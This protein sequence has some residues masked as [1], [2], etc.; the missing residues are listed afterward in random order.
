VLKNLHNHFPEAK[1]DFLAVPSSRGIL[2]GNPIVNNSLFFDRR[3]DSSA[4]FLWTLRRSQYDLVIDLYGNPRTAL[5]TYFSAAKYRVGFAFRGRRY[6]YNIHVPSRGGE[7]HNLEFNLDVLRPLGI[8][9]IDR[10]IPFYIAREDEEYVEEFLF[11]NRLEHETIVA[12]NPG[13]TWYTKQW[14]LRKFAELG[15][16]L[17]EAYR[18]KIVLVWGPGEIEKAQRIQNLMRQPSFIP[19]PTTL[20][21]LAALFKKCAFVV[22]NDAGPMHLAAVLGIPTLGIYGPTNPDYQGPIGEKNSWVRLNGLDC[23]G[24]NLTS[25]PIGHLCMERL[26][27]D[28]VMR[29]VQN[30]VEQNQ[31]F[32]LA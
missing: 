24:C 7:V 2:E 29:A 5:M 11:Q 15:D 12:L 30:L 32:V 17:A 10:S 20:K 27:V 26:S 19:P 21:Q 28:A 6:A 4:S 9:V 14:G 1:I 8:E 23:L 25:C 22:S 18:A 13:G 16:V 31:I 3:N